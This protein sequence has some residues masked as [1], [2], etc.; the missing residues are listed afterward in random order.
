[1]ENPDANAGAPT[2]S[3][4]GVALSGQFRNYAAF[5]GGWTRLTGGGEPAGHQYDLV[6]RHPSSTPSHSPTIHV[7]TKP[8]I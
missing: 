4:R 3:L 6:R 1:M 5:G 2:M 8:T 7:V